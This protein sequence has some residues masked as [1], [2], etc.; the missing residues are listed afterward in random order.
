M[1]LITQIGSDLIAALKLAQSIAEKFQS[2]KRRRLWLP[3][4]T[5][6]WFSSRNPTPNWDSMD[7]DADEFGEFQAHF[8]SMTF[9]CLTPSIVHGAARD[10]SDGPY[11]S[12]QRKDIV[13]EEE[14]E[15]ASLGPNIKKKIAPIHSYRDIKR[16]LKGAWASVL[17][18]RIRFSK[19]LH[20]L[21]HSP[22]PRYA[23]KNA[24]GVALLSLP[25]FL[26]SGGQH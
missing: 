20:S 13:Q 6:T 16:Y 8:S 10:Y 17:E 2:R 24:F 26:P 5:K 19:L 25:A 9:K 22:H 1:A 21:T 11:P 4:L 7:L 3:K 18:P 23:F 15:E 14:A 12:E